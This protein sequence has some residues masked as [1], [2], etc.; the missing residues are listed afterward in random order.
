MKPYNLS[1]KLPVLLKWVGMR[2]WKK[3]QR[4]GMERGYCLLY[5]LIPP[6]PYTEQ[7][8]RWREALRPL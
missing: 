4:E 1:G 8:E 6:M 7:L 2:F 3:D 5:P